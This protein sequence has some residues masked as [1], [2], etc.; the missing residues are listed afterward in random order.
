MSEQKLDRI[1]DFLVQEI[2][3]TSDEEIMENADLE[4][5]EHTRKVILDTVAKHKEQEERACKYSKEDWMF[6]S[7]GCLNI[8]TDAFHKPNWVYCP[9]CG[10]RIV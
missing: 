4:D 5:I 1:R 3:N 2:L 7:V 6:H 9:Y 10:G 8:K